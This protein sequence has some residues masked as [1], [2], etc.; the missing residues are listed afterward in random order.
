MVRRVKHPN[1]F[2]KWPGG[3]GKSL[4]AIADAAPASWT[5]YIE[6]FIGGGAVF[7][8]LGRTGPKSILGDANADLIG[9]YTVVRDDVDSLIV[10][11][12]AHQE[13]FD[14]DRVG[15][16]YAVRALDPASL[17]PVDAA[18]RIVFLNRTCF[19][20]MYRVNKSGAFN[21]PIGRYANPKIC[22]EGLLQ[23]CSAA[24]AGAEIIH[25][26]F[27]AT[28]AR[29]EPGAFVYLD[30]PYVPASATADFSSYTAQGFGSRDH[31][32][33]LAQLRVLTEQDIQFLL[34]SSD[35]YGLRDRYES[36]G[37]SVTEVSV[38]RNVNRDASK[39]GPVTEL[40]VSNY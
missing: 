29:A 1:P 20:G 25:S 33:L 35:A 17:S 10:L 37:W 26:G 30:P 12:H 23:V 21:V 28:M 4:P 7:F 36:E 31:V 13:A 18:A 11:L 6:P 14:A 32:D 9:A 19:N 5:E 34:S 22:N 24:L 15:H 3:K 27:A 38:R 40:L 39:R 8:G 16:Y 2:M